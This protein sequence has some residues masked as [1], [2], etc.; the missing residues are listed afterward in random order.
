MVCVC[1]PKNQGLTHSRYF[2]PTPASASPALSCGSTSRCQ[3]WP[4]A[5]VEGQLPNIPHLLAVRHLKDRCHGLGTDRHELTLSVFLSQRRKRVC[6]K[7]TETLGRRFTDSLGSCPEGA[8][9]PK[10]GY[11]AQVGV[12]RGAVQPRRSHA[13]QGGVS[14][15]GRGVQ[16]RKAKQPLTTPLG[17]ELL[18][19]W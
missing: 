13:A 5:E 18:Q 1:L 16:P 10:L 15:L 3:G 7:A 14:R 11:L 6:L 4:H 8:V 17:S 9:Q 19:G 12:S 2:P